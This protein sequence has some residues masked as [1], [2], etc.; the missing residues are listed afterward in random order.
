MQL[1]ISKRTVVKFNR[2]IRAKIVK[3]VDNLRLARV[4]GVGRI[5]E[6]DETHLHTNRRRMVGESFWIFSGICRETKKV[7]LKTITTDRSLKFMNEF[8]SN[9]VE[10]DTTIITNGCRGYRF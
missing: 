2:L 4:G 10:S 8:I 9:N 3:H 7:F 1:K 6:I 5:V